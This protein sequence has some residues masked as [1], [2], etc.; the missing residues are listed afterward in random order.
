VAR[1]QQNARAK[2]ALTRDEQAQLEAL[3]EVELTSG[4]PD[5]PAAI[6]AKQKICLTVV[7]DSGVTGAA[8]RAARR[9]CRRT[10]RL[11]PPPPVPQSAP[12]SSD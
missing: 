6:A 4:S 7:K 10:G 3:C 11:T 9:R 8:A 5:S 1:C 2:T 12:G